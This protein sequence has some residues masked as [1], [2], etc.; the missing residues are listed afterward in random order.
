[1][2]G[3]TA[4]ARVLYQ[5]SIALN[6]SLGNEDRAVREQHNLAWM[7]LHDDNTDRARELFAAVRL[8]VVAQDYGE[9]VAYAALG[10]AAVAVRDGA[11]LQATR[12]LGVVATALGEN[13][14]LDPDDAMEH[15]SLRDRLVAELGRGTFD[16]EY[17]NGSELLPMEAI[18][19][20]P[21]E[22]FAADVHPDRN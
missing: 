1:M 3:D 9:F 6:E 17:A 18:S 21:T 16:T 20:L 22:R 7:E 5:E 10:A 11:Y 4:A 13:D 2:A 8:Y 12:L 14:Q 15:V 19:A